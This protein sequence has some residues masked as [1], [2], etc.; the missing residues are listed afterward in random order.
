MDVHGFKA[1]RT[2]CNDLLR[3]MNLRHVVQRPTRAKLQRTWE[4]KGQHS[5]LQVC[6]ASLCELVANIFTR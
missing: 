1:G 5:G 4:K 2:W 6:N 3:E